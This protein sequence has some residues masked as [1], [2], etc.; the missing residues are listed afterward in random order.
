MPKTNRRLDSISTFRQRTPT[1]EQTADNFTNMAQD[2]SRQKAVVPTGWG[3]QGGGGYR[4]MNEGG[5]PKALSVDV[6]GVP[7]KP[8]APK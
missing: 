5:R 3:T 6:G 4:T 2:F 7:N 1:N 8:G